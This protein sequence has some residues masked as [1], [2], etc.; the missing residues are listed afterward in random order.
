MAACCKWSQRLTAA[1]HVAPGR[2][3]LHLSCETAAWQEAA[4]VSNTLVIKMALKCSKHAA[5]SSAARRKCVQHLT[6]NS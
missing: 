5:S 4:L 3:L 2:L 6:L 1:A